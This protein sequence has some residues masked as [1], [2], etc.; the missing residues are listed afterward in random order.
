[1]EVLMAHV[2]MFKGE[3]VSSPLPHFAFTGD[4]AVSGIPKDE[5]QVT[6]TTAPFVCEEE[7]RKHQRSS[8][9]AGQVA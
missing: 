9:I 1:M 2:E 6:R 5:N 3:R 4:M 7:A 8:P